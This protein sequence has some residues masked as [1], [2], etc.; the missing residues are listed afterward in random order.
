MPNIILLRG[1]PVKEE[2]K[3]GVAITPGM[4]LQWNAGT[5]R[6][7]A[8]AADTAA[9]PIFADVNIVPDRGVATAAIDTPYAVNERVQYFH[10]T[11]GD[12]VY[13]LLETGANVARGAALESNGAGALQAVT[14]GRIVGFAAEA[15]NNASGSNVRI[16]V[17]V[18]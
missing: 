15:V 17:E 2:G 9:I 7:N 16:R 13:A 8:T 12:M 1:K 6:P 4:L 18:A 11:S 14:T 5:L 3:C 10:C